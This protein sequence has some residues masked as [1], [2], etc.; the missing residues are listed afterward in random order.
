MTFMVYNSFEKF[1]QPFPIRTRTETA[2]TMAYSENICLSRT[3]QTIKV[4]K[5]WESGEKVGR[6]LWESCEKVMRKWWES[7]EKVVRKLWE[8]CEKVL[9]SCEKDVRKLSDSCEKVVRKSL[10]LYFS[11]RS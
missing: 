10:L 7:C 4:R 6:N 1:W 8:S 5:L 11:W 3:L 2:Q 9:K